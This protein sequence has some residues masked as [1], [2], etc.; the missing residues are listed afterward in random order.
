M[1]VFEIYKNVFIGWKKLYLMFWY[2][3]N[4]D[5][6]FIKIVFIFKVMKGVKIELNLK[7]G[8]KLSYR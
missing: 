4:F 5:F 7:W 3:I 1:L 6:L 2:K 8:R